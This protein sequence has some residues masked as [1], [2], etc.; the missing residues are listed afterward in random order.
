M[1]PPTQS[2]A[3]PGSVNFIREISEDS[4]FVG[5]HNI[6]VHD[7]IEDEHSGDDDR[8]SFESGEDNYDQLSYSRSVPEDEDFD[9]YDA[10]NISDNPPQKLN[11]GNQYGEEIALLPPLLDSNQ[12]GSPFK[13]NYQN[14]PQSS[15][16]VVK[17]KDKT[18]MIVHF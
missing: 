13:V 2:L 1:A 12:F 16:K 3:R 6:E 7:D 8:E 9:Y 11:K 15:S 14:S 5:K 10:K 18:W 17:L 4:V